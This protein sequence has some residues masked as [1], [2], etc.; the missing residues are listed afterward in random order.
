VVKLQLNDAYR[1]LRKNRHEIYRISKLISESLP[2]YLTNCFFNAQEKRINQ[3][4]R[5]ETTRID[6]KIELLIKRDQQRRLSN[7]HPIQYYAEKKGSTTHIQLIPNI[8]KN[9]HFIKIKPGINSTTKFEN[10][11]DDK[12][13]INLSG[14][15]IPKEVQ[16]LLQLGD[17]FALPTMNSNLHNTIIEIIKQTENNITNLKNICEND[18]RNRTISGINKLY[19]NDKPMNHIDALLE[20]WLHITKN[21]I[22]S[23]PNILFTRADKGNTTVALDRN[24][25]CSQMETLLHNK[26]TYEIVKNDPS[27]KLIS[28]LISLISYW[29][30]QNF[31]DNR[32][33]KKI[34]CSDGPLPR[35]YG[36][37]KIHKPGNPLRIIVSSI[38][39]PLYSLATYLHDIIQKSIPKSS[40][41][42]KNSY[43]LVNQLDGK[44]LDSQHSLASLDVVSLFTNVPSELVVESIKRR[45][46][47]IANNTKIPIEQFIKAL[48]FIMDSTFF[49]FNKVMYKQIFGTPMGS[50][51]SP[52]IADIVMQDLERSAIE[53]LPFELPFFYRYVDDI[54]FAAPSDMLDVALDSF[55][56]VHERLQFTMEIEREGKI[57]FLEVLFTRDK[58]I[59]NFDLYHKPTFSGKFLNFHS[60]HPITHKR[61]V[62]IGLTDKILKL[63]H[64]KFHLKNFTETINLLQRNVGILSNSFFH[65][66][67]NRIKNWIFKK[68]NT[69]DTTNKEKKK[70]SPLSKKCQT[71]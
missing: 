40:S 25:Y 6:K 68:T 32:T 30:K 43:H 20:N 23:H 39:S 5:C 36:L 60:H 54:I 61:G 42:I 59:L 69:T 66:I 48:N 45:W 37:P 51:L 57:N 8:S 9:S 70:F 53:K 67:N 65:T 55:N 38:N 17:R 58:N 24:K 21:F 64:P 62:V 52:I 7:V 41:F 35:A 13:F 1:Q 29:K 27:K 10:F 34:Y 33:Y 44:T 56:Q 18:I 49:T 26:D 3:I 28:S 71:G 50:P 14:V 46:S 63:T 11:L 47:L 22:K 31:I 4:W 19:Y 15:T 16:Q 12:W 2:L